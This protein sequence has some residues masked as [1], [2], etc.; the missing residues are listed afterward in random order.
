[1]LFIFNHE[2]KEVKEVTALMMVMVAVALAA[3]IGMESQLAY[4]SNSFH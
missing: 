2:V 3:A 4:Y 1:L